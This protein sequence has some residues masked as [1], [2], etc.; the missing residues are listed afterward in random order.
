MDTVRFAAI[1][2]CF[3]LSVVTLGTGSSAPVSAQQG[4]S[5]TPIPTNTT[6]NTSLEESEEVGSGGAEVN[7]TLE[8]EITHALGAEN[9]EAG[10]LNRVRKIVTKRSGGSFSC[11]MAC[12]PKT[13]D[14]LNTQLTIASRNLITGAKAVPTEVWS[15]NV[16]LENGY[17]MTTSFGASRDVLEIMKSDSH[18]Q[19]IDIS[20]DENKQRF[21]TFLVRAEMKGSCPQNQRSRYTCSI[22]DKVLSLGVSRSSC[23]SNGKE[24]WSLVTNLKWRNCKLSGN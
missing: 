2:L 3:A 7:R 10:L 9:D 23:D 13:F 16:N 19:C 14:E 5:N 17:S 22:I 12:I 24:S 1:L 8:E 21:P 6:A 15:V 4:G 20:F 18:S 11:S